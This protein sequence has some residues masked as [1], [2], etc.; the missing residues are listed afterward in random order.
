MSAPLVLILLGAPGSGKGT[1]AKQLTERFGTPQV[2]TGDMFRQ[3]VKQGTPLG[4][5]AR[6]YMDR[7]ALVPDSV[8]VGLVKE[9]ILKPACARGFLLDGFPRTVAQAEALDS[10]MASLGLR[11]SLVLNLDVDRPTLLR[12]LGGRRMCR[13][14]ERGNFNVYTLA[15][16]VEGVCDFCG[17][18]L[19]QREDDK[20]SVIQARLEVYEAQTAP[21]IAWYEGRGIL[22]RLA[23]SGSVESMVARLAEAIERRRVAAG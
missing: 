17:G 7:G 3:A 10:L 6:G 22:A 13:G 2:S 4:L 9:R 11:V 8:T 23:F 18:E 21:L 15:P 5:E 19:Y 1:Y 20:E 14:C 12:R 16:K